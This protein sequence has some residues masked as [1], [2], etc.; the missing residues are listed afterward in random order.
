[1]A[2]VLGEV[3]A[4]YRALVAG[5]VAGEVLGPAGRAF[6]DFVAWSGGLD[7]G[8]AAGFWRERLAGVGAAAPVGVSSWT[9]WSRW[10][11]C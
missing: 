11:G 10:S 8:A 2:L 7:A 3:F 6:R 9:V 4:G 1:V 5:G